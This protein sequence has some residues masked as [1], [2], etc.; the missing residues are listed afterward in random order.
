MIKTILVPV[1]GGDAD[2]AVF[3]TALT[4]ARPLLAHLGVPPRARQAGRGRPPY[5]AR[6]LR[7]WRRPSQRFARLG[8]QGRDACCRGCTPRLRVLRAVE[9]R[10]GRQASRRARRHRTV[11]ARGGRCPAASAVACAP[12][13]P[14]DHGARG[15][16]RRASCGP[17]GNAAAAVRA[18]AAHCPGQASAGAA[19]YGNGL[20]EGDAGRRSSGPAAMRPPDQR[21]TCGRRRRRGGWCATA[22]VRSMQSSISSP[23]TAWMPR[24]RL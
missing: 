5:A 10:Y 16:V 19:R 4:V 7:P 15:K 3:E 21:A 12:Q 6:R 2:E 11:A 20:L 22:R 8:R 18:P 17:P 14:G 24:A 1:G 13:R 9:D 23:G